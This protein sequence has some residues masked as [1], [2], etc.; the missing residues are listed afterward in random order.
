VSGGALGPGAFLLGA[1][2]EAIT[3]AAA[4]G[5]ATIVVARRLDQLTGPPRIV[6]LALLTIAATLLS[7]LIPLALGIMTRATV[8]LT[9]LAIALAVSR[10]PSTAAPAPAPPR[11][12]APASTA[13]GWR[14]PAALA[15][16]ATATAWLA[17]LETA[18]TLHIT[19]V[20]ALSFH[21][22]GVIRFIQSGTLWQ[23]TQYLPGQAQG[24]YPQNGDLLLLA[25]AL[26]WHS[27]AFVR[28]A[29]PVLLA[30][31][32]LAS[33]ALARELGAP[34]PAAVLTTLALIAIRPVL[35]PALL[36]NL[37]D[38]TFLAGFAAGAL[39]LVR[40]WRTG[41]RAELV[42]AG[43]GLGIAL[44]TKWYGLP[45]VPALIVVW[46]IA[47]RV[48]KRPLARDA[49]ILI[50]VTALA[51]G[52]WLV[53]NLVLTGDPVFDYR[54]SLLG[55]TIFPAPPDTIERVV[56]F[57]LAHY[58]TNS[59]VLRHYVWP[60]LRSDFGLTGAL[61]AIGALVTAVRSRDRRVHVLIAGAVL[62][63]VAYVITPYSAQGIAGAPTQIVANTRYGAPAL[64]LAAPLLAVAI[65]RAR[66]LRPLLELA[67]LGLVLDDLHRY[68]PASA[69]RLVITGLAVL[70]LVALLAPVRALHRAG[71]PGGSRPA[72]PAVL[73][74][75]ACLAAA[76]AYHYQR[77]L[78]ATPYTPEDPTIEYVLARAPAHTRIGLA[79][80]WTAQGVVPV[81]VMFGP[82]MQ[83]TVGY[84]GPFVAHRLAQY[85]RPG[86]FIAALRRDRY[87]LLE[88][89]TGIPPVAVPDA[90]RWAR[91]A[92]YSM[93]ARSP[94][95]VLMRAGS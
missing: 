68:L 22:P 78:A 5:S 4:A 65:G 28:Y 61:I 74:V 56:G 80:Q 14:L 29:D 20:D 66:A 30:L 82:R 25:L 26:P 63:A 45:D 9:A 19:S 77:V 85:S 91:A 31:A 36:D 89:G 41:A 79:G 47:A 44:G 95:L 34:R 73:A 15:L 46:A 32:A 93:V 2:L 55:A 69:P 57:T 54:V 83:N 58:L 27:L 64:V 40:H 86:P 51:G 1:L 53:R 84:V 70:V 3:L 87:R 92:G 71:R 7:E 90:A 8:P 16:L 12:P 75:L 33:Y 60:A 37:T 81:A 17:Y 72:R 43:V 13:N 52:I 42:L 35:G 23:H 6:A 62:A 59:S 21:L 50:A 38:P 39:F 94:R 18:A 88:I 48:A 10:L 67:L 76:L 49:G 24:N 11:R